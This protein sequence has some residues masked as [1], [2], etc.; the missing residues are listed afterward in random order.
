MYRLEK[1]SIENLDQAQAM[2][3]QLNEESIKLGIKMNVS[4]NLSKTK[5]MTNIDDDND[6]KIGDTVI[7]RVDSYVGISRS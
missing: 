6:I 3:H 1:V 7:V 5:L 4:S 2:L